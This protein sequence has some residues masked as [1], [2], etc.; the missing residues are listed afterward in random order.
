MLK[1]AVI[2]NLVPEKKREI[3][4]STQISDDS[5][6]QDLDYENEQDERFNMLKER[7]DKLE[8]IVKKLVEYL[9]RYSENET[10]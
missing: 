2:N 1:S 10:P 9:I 5:Q 8:I 4:F 6:D 7:I 3:L